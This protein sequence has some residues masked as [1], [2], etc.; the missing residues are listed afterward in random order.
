MMETIVGL[1]DLPATR[2]TSKKQRSAHSHE[3]FS[4]FFNGKKRIHIKWIPLGLI[5]A[6]LDI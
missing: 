6:K 1:I 3:F 5:F 4:G 2:S